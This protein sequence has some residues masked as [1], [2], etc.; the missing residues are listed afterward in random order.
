MS[1]RGPGLSY[2]IR[3]TTSNNKTGDN[4]AITIPRIIAH[5][6]E[7]CFFKMC[8]S[9][10]SIIFESG[11]KMSVNDIEVDNQKKIFTAGGVISFR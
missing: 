1:Y 3:R 2:R 5:K 10:N 8:V 6:F 7:A 11:C 9:G 4:Y